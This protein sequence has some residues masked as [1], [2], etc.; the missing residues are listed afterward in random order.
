MKLKTQIKR[1]Y[2]WYI[3]GTYHCDKCPMCWSEWSYEGDGDCGCHIFGDIRDTCR[4]L[5]PLRQLIGW[6]RKKKAEYWASHQYD[7][8]PAYMEAQEHQLTALT[9]ILT[10]ELKLYEICWRGNDGV[11]EPAYDCKV[12]FIENL[13]S[14]I[15]FDYETQMHPYGHIPL[16]T[17]WHNV[18]GHT[19]EAFLNCFR[20]YLPERKSKKETVTVDDIIRQIAT[21]NYHGELSKRAKELSWD[22]YAEKDGW[23]LE[24]AVPGGDTFCFIIEGQQVVEEIQAFANNFEV[25]THLLNY[26]FFTNPVC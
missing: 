9:K 13:A 24:T 17:E 1:A 25:N 26:C 19:W 15:R 11:L 21:D 2:N 20:P 5:P 14:S 12:D 8:L 22:I 23:H 16:K 7:D 4:L 10:K 18:I 6:P 3:K